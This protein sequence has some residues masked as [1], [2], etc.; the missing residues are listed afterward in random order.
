[1]HVSNQTPVTQ[2]I[3]NDHGPYF[4]AQQNGG[5]ANLRTLDLNARDVFR[6]RARVQYNGMTH[7]RGSASNHG[8]FR[9]NPWGFV[10]FFLFLKHF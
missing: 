5:A 6:E 9:Q 10:K 2:F 4:N 8:M 1:M 3:P 7:R